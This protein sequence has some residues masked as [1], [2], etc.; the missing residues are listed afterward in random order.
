MD[1][2]GSVAADAAAAALSYSAEEIA[3]L[4]DEY[5]RK[6]WVAIRDFVPPALCE[7][8]IEEAT[9]LL[10]SDAAFYSTDAHTV[11]QE[12]EDTKFSCEHP[13]N[14]LQQS[15]KRIVDYARL[16]DQSPLR[17]LYLQPALLALVQRIVSPETES[18]SL[19]LSDCPFNA[20]YYNMYRE[21]DGLGWHFDKGEFGVNLVLQN[22][23]SGGNFEFHHNTLTATDTWAFDKVER[24]LSGDSCGVVSSDG[25]VGAGSL[26]IF[27]GRQS[28]HRVSPVAGLIPRINAIFVYESSPGQRLGRYSL[29]KFF[30]RIS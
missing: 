15:S 8:L 21:G 16:S 19:Y 11:Y 17:L 18:K 23:V 13:R 24:I 1:Q 26:V 7:T 5:G 20:A 14:A 4:R 30:G 29:H 25:L 22:P 6:G 12:S 10:E 3:C 27:N 2:T 28:M 9:A